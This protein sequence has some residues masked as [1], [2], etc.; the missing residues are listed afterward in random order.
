VQC[1]KL[2]IV[3][4]WEGKVFGKIHQGQQSHHLLHQQFSSFLQFRLKKVCCP[5]FSYTT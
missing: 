4:S 1:I 3:I 5:S 2:E